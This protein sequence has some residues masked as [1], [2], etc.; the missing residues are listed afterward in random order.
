MSHEFIIFKDLP[1]IS[2]ERCF[3]ESASQM[4]GGN[5][6][7]QN[8]GTHYDK[9]FTYQQAMENKLRYDDSFAFASVE[10][11]THVRYITIGK[12]E[13]WKNKND[14]FHNEFTVFGKDKSGSRSYIYNVENEYGMLGNFLKEQ[15][16]KWGLATPDENSTMDQL[17]ESDLYKNCLGPYMNRN[18]DTGKE[19]VY[20]L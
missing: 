1:K 17:F 12:K 9:I 20:L 19:Y 3:A 8:L 14:T 7:Y 15:G 16:F 4:F 10:D 18:L 13:S 6:S 11:K 2:F 5:V